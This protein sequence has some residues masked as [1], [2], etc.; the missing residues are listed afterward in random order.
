[1][2][3]EQV[4]GKPLDPRTDIYSFGVSCYHMLAGQPP[5]RG[6][7]AFEVALQHVRAEPEPLT[8]V[9]PDLPAELCAVVH[10]MMA[11]R[12]EDRY[13][14]CRELLAD[15]SRLR[16]GPV[17]AQAGGVVTQRLASSGAVPLVDSD[18]GAQAGTAGRVTGLV[19]GA[20]TGA[21]A[22]RPR[23]RWLPWAV[24]G[25]VLLAA[26]GG[27][28]LGWVR[29]QAGTKAAAAQAGTEAA[30]PRP[31]PS[32]AEREKFLQT[33]VQ[34]YL[35]PSGATPQEVNNQAR[36]GIDHAVE[37]A[38]FYLDRWKLNEADDLFGKLTAAGDKV[39][40][41]LKLGR[42]GH[43]IVLGLQDKP[44]ESNKL[45]VEVVGRKA[46]R[47]RLLQMPWFR[48][49]P[50]LQLWIARALEHNEQNAP[51]SFPPQLRPWQEPPPLPKRPADKPA[52]GRG[53]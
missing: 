13:Q 10:K 17:G 20:T 49:N 23:R 40:Q 36:L 2:S 25:S 26:T 9:R 6:Q 41:Y 51:E 18:S 28:A 21:P 45:F 52:G 39:P 30:E 12:P 47:D 29:L 34:Q 38:L 37:L 7:S 48:Q 8:S 35:K 15:L 24:A 4:E 43:A 33:A 44:E 50:K 31:A 32:E 22:A 16:E 42:I 5:F 27:A 3:P 11:K 19:P 14:S 1:M 46:E 53:T